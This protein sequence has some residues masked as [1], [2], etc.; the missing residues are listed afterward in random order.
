ME[1]YFGDSDLDNGGTDDIIDDTFEIDDLTD[2]IKLQA[3]HEADSLTEYP[4]SSGKTTYS[5]PLHEKATAQQIM[6]LTFPLFLNPELAMSKITF[7]GSTSFNGPT[8]FGDRNRIEIDDFNAFVDTSLK[9]EKLQEAV[10]LL[11]ELHTLI[12]NSQEIQEPHKLEAKNNL[13]T[14]TA[15]LSKAEGEQ[16]KPKI[17]KQWDVLISLIQDVGSIVNVATAVG[18][19]LGLPIP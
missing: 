13:R 8:Q 10:P 4:S 1:I 18:K 16:D 14:I 11:I 2:V 6:F 7:Q 17:K 9:N 19:I 12:V 15:E 5:K 3:S